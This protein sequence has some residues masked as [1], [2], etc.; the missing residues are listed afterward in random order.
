LQ[1]I[2]LEAVV[3][4]PQF[5]SVSF[6]L[7][8]KKKNAKL[9]AILPLLTPSLVLICRSDAGVLDLARGIICSALSRKS[10]R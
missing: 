6:N 8:T 10:F 9:K 1:A 3:E 5:L 4:Y 2:P 7:L